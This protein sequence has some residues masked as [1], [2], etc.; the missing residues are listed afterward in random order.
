[1]AFSTVCVVTFLRNNLLAYVLF[2]FSV[3]LQSAKDLAATNI[4][5][6]HLQAIALSVLVLLIIFLLWCRTR[7]A[8]P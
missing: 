6:F 2:G 1:M 8:P 3:S 7:S 4:S 5:S